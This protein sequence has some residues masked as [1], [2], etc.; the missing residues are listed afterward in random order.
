VPILYGV[1]LKKK[2]VKNK[3]VAFDENSLKNNKGRNFI[4]L[5]R[6]VTGKQK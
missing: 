1:F 4:S 6:C 2:M 3:Y 5:G